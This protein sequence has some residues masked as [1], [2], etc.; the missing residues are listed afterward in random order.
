MQPRKLLPGLVA[1]LCLLCVPALAA[2]PAKTEPAKAA[3]AKA[4]AS[5]PAGVVAEVFTI[6][7]PETDIII[8]RERT[9]SRF[10]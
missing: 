8:R 6:M 4:E 10:R 5:A 3:P 7:P 1:G 2:E 9:S